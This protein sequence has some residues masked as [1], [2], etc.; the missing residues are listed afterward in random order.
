MDSL[1][2]GEEFAAWPDATFGAASMH[3]IG[4]SDSVHA[5]ENFQGRLANIPSDQSFSAGL[6]ALQLVAT[7]KNGKIME[8][9]RR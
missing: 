6:G 4:P 2:T 3:A 5:R 9:P 1:R 7:A 8:H